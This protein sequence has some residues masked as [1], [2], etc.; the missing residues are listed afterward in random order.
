M[1]NIHGGSR[2]YFKK[3][4]NSKY[5]NIPIILSHARYAQARKGLEQARDAKD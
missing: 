1:K 5:G 4:S 2:F 3:A